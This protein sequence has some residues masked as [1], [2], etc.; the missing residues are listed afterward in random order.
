MLI[1][2]E[3]LDDVELLTIYLY[4][5]RFENK[6]RKIE[7]YDY[8][9]RYLLSW[10]PNLPNYSNFNARLNNLSGTIPYLVEILE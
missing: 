3:K 1:K 8:A 9:K 7:I 5:R 6:H 4:C 2:N 10:F